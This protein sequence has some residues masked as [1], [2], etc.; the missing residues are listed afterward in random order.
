MSTY[1]SSCCF[2]AIPHSFHV[3]RNRLMLVLMK[4]E[5]LDQLCI[6][7]LDCRTQEDLGW[8][9]GKGLNPS[10]AVRETPYVIM[11]CWLSQK[12]CFFTPAFLL[13]GRQHEFPSLRPACVWRV[14]H[15]CRDA[16]TH[17]QQVLWS[18]EVWWV[19]NWAW[20]FIQIGM[21]F[22]L[23]GFGT[24]AWLHNIDT[25]KDPSVW[26]GISRFELGLYS[27]HASLCIMW[28]PLPLLH[29][30]MPKFELVIDPP[31]YIQDLNM[32]EQ[33]TVRARWVTDSHHSLQHAQCDFLTHI[34]LWILERQS[35]TSTLVK[36]QTTFLSLDMS[37]GSQWPGRWQWTWQWMELGTTGMRWA[38]LWSRPWR[39]VNPA[40]VLKNL[41]LSGKWNHI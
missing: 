30:V 15:L 25:F 27:C 39:W 28:T 29:T 24:P 14:V 20:P 11:W 16:G 3:G 17:L 9:S 41:K 40:A 6:H 37:L 32:C 19:D 1:V 23:K 12:H 8:S 38:I 36:T 18:A 34:V 5:S 2:R 21:W 7:T 33:A 26:G 31:Q 13:R 35:S 4:V 22:G 10:A